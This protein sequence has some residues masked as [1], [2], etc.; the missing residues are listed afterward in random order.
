MKLSKPELIAILLYAPGKTG[1]IGEP[2]VGRTRLM[3]LVFLLLKEGG[4]AE[5]VERATT[6]KPYKYGPFDPEVFDSIEALK[7]LNIV[8][9]KVE[10]QSKIEDEMLEDIDETYD[11]D[12][13]YRLTPQGIAKV[14][15]IVRQLPA[16]VLRRISNYKSIYG[17]KPLIEV[18]HYVY[19]KYP[20][21]AELSEANI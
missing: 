11:A 21:Y 19:S 5:D 8:E 16:D 4:L 1:N 14:E 17:D 10:P 13:V 20:K 15:R 7:E 6:F 2:I 9:E 12:T 3:K 18:L